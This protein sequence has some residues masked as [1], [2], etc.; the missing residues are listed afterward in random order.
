MIKTETLVGYLS[1]KLS[2]SDHMLNL[3][4]WVWQNGYSLH[5]TSGVVGGG[6][7]IKE[8]GDSW[9]FIPYADVPEYIHSLDA[10][11]SLL[12]PNWGWLVE[13][14]QHEKSWAQVVCRA[15]GETEPSGVFAGAE[16]SSPARALCLA[17]FK[18]R[19]LADKARDDAK[20]AQK[21]QDLLEYQ[22]LC[23]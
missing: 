12:P 14:W 22:D 13:E 17:I 2:I 18:A 4:L 3:L 16:A 7:R 10:A 15:K 1:G 5:D 9:R 23:K 19:V 6:V 20:D 8:G 11:R 21:Y